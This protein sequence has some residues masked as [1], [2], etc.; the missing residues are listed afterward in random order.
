MFLLTAI[1][2]ATCFFFQWA[3]WVSSC[4]I[5]AKFLAK[6]ICNIVMFLLL[7]ASSSS[8]LWWPDSQCFIISSEIGNRLLNQWTADKVFMVYIHTYISSKTFLGLRD[9]SLDCPATNFE[10]WFLI[11]IHLHNW[12]YQMPFLYSYSFFIFI[13]HFNFIM[14][15]WWLHWYVISIIKGQ[16][17]IYFRCIE[18]QFSPLKDT[19]RKKHSS[20]YKNLN[21][22]IWVI[23]TSLTLFKRFLNWNKFSKK[24]K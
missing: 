15:M 14:G 17:K 13:Q 19:H 3:N 12:H 16:N 23:G 24:I 2:K 4:Q 11:S 10:F 8:C 20:T 22:D 6:S 7:T 18:K 9:A 21:M 5:G 1:R